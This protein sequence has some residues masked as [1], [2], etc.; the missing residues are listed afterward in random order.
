MGNAY[1][2]LGEPRR[3][4]EHY[5]RVLA[6]ARE[7]GDRR[8]EGD[9]LGN[10]GS[11]YSDLGEPRRAIVHYERQLAIAREIGD[12]RGEGNAQFNSALALDQLG[13]RDEAIRRMREAVFI[14]K[15]IEDP[16]RERAGAMLKEWQGENIPGEPH[17]S[18]GV[19]GKQGRASP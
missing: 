15:Q 5:E 19:G 1:A 7:I 4:I 6:I 16:W 13:E 18:S 2:A 17:G 3:A 12:R 9:S 10:L 11:A 14:F 8:I